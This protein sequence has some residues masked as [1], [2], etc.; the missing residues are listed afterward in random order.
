ME[1]WN[2]DV[3]SAVISLKNQGYKPCVLN[4]SGMRASGVD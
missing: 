4:L 3:V 2:C 1:V